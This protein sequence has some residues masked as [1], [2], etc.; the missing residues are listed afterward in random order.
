ML[1]RIRRLRVDDYANILNKALRT[2]YDPNG[3]WRARSRE[4]C[5]ALAHALLETLHESD[6]SPVDLSMFVRAAAAG[7]KEVVQHLLD[8]GADPNLYESHDFGHE[9]DLCKGKGTAFLAAVSNGQDSVVDLLLEQGADVNLGTWDALRRHDSPTALMLA[10]QKGHANIVQKL[11]DAGADIDATNGGETA[12]ICAAIEGNTTIAEMLLAADA[13]MDIESDWWG[14][15]LTAAVFCKSSGVVKVLLDAGANVLTRC[16]GE[17]AEQDSLEGL[18]LL[19][20]ARR[21]GNVEVAELLRQAGASEE[22]SDGSACREEKERHVRDMEAKLNSL[23]TANS[24]IQSEN[25]RLKAMLQRAET[26]NEILRATGP[27][28]PGMSH[29][30]GFIDDVLSQAGHPSSNDE[31]PSNAIRFEQGLLS[32]EAT[33][34]PRVRHGTSYRPSSDNDPHSNASRL[35][36]KD[37]NED[38]YEC[39][40]FD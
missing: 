33:L 32:A 3:A 35:T 1:K 13:S 22:V 34:F 2:V 27:S 9:I 37:T 23:T 18:T 38:I 8:R 24:S 12:L 5:E 39:T 30:R 10:V 11:I 40:D 6:T 7:H 31:P 28:S 26:E 36:N 4:E 16:Y 19:E 15:A 17:V 25:E 20:A 29:P 21:K 14:T